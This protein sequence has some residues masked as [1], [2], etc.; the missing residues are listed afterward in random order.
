[1]M[2]EVCSRV[3]LLSQNSQQTERD[4]QEAKRERQERVKVPTSLLR[5]FP[6]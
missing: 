4:R 5:V 1:M 6:K 2:V 3:K